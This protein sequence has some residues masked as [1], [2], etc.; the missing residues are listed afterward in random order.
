MKGKKNEEFLKNLDLIRNV[1]EISECKSMGL[2]PDST[3]LPDV[4]LVDGLPSARHTEAVW[5]PHG[6]FGP[7]AIGTFD[8]KMYKIKQN[9]YRKAKQRFVFVKVCI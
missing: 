9:C 1:P 8:Q 4:N 3:S 7:A 6:V 2:Y 5:G